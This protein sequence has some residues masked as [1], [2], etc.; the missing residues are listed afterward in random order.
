[1]NLIS[2]SYRNVVDLLYF[3]IEK[4][5]VYKDEKIINELLDCILHDNNIILSDVVRGFTEYESLIQVA[6]EELFH[7]ICKT[8]NNKM[9]IDYNI[10]FFVRNELEAIIKDYNDNYFNEVENQSF[11]NDWLNEGGWLC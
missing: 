4:D 7:Y 3:Y 9:T 6:Y 2:V 5:N 10:C 8:K 1:M 11:L